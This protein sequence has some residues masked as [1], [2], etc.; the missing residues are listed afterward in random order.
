MPIFY[1]TIPVQHPDR[2]RCDRC[3]RDFEDMRSSVSIQH[4]FGYDAPAG[5]DGEIAD[6]VLCE[7]CLLALAQEC[8]MVPSLESRAE[9]TAHNQ[10]D[11]PER[12]TSEN[13]YGFSLQQA[14]HHPDNGKRGFW[15]VTGVRHSALVQSDSA[16]N[17]KDLAST[18]VGEWEICAIEFLGT[19]L[20][21]V[22]GL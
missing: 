4:T 10:A 16:L 3:K 11:F 1:K 9:D 22:F 13:F 17:A 18:L 19:T 21:E 15:K 5:W 6:L 12:E 14:Q 8:E 2:F 20:P 7:A